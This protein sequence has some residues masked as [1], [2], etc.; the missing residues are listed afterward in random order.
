[1]EVWRRVTRGAILEAFT[2]L[3]LQYEAWHTI[4]HQRVLVGRI[5][6]AKQDA[7]LIRLKKVWMQLLR[8]SKSSAFE[9]FF[10]NWSRSQQVEAERLVVLAKQ[11]AGEA[12]LRKTWSKW[13]HRHLREVCDSLLQNFAEAKVLALEHEIEQ[14]R[15]I[16]A[17]AK[18]GA[19]AKLKLIWIHKLKG[20]EGVALEAL[21]ENYGRWLAWREEWSNLGSPRAHRDS[22]SIQIPGS[23][24]LHLALDND[25]AEATIL[26]LIESNPVAAK[27]TDDKGRL[28]VH[29]A[30]SRIA[31][32]AS[33]DRLL[34]AY[35]CATVIPDNKGDLPI[36]IAARHGATVAA[37]KLL[38]GNI[39][40]AMIVNHVGDTA[41][42]TAT[43]HSRRDAQMVSLLIEACPE[44]AACTNQE[45]RTALHVAVSHG[46][47]LGLGAKVRH[48]KRGEGLVK[49]VMSDGRLRV[50]FVGGDMHRYGPRSWPKLQVIQPAAGAG[51]DQ[52]AHEKVVALLLE[53]NKS[54]TTVA[55]HRRDLPIH[56]AAT[57][58]AP[59]C[60]V[61]MLLQAS[62][63]LKAAQ[64][65]G[66]E[67]DSEARVPW[68][69]LKKF[70]SVTQDSD[71]LTPL[72][73]AVAQNRRD[74]A[75]VLT[76]LLDA[77]KEGAVMTDTMGR[78]P[79]HH[80]MRAMLEPEVVRHLAAAFPSAV[81]Q[82]DK[83]GLT[84]VE[85]MR[86]DRSG[87]TDSSSLKE[88]KMTEAE[89]LMTCGLSGE[90]LCTSL[91]AKELDVARKCIENE[92]LNLQ[93]CHPA[94]FVNA[95][96]AMPLHMALMHQSPEDIIFVLLKAHPE[97][98]ARR[99]ALS[100]FSRLI[101]T[102][103]GV[104]ALTADAL[105]HGVYALQI[106]A[107]SQASEAVKRQVFLAF[108]GAIANAS[109]F[110]AIRGNWGDE[111]VAALLSADPDAIQSPDV[112]G[113]M[114]VH[115]A[116]ELDRPDATVKR[117]LECH[118][119]AAQTRDASGNLPLDVV[120]DS[121]GFAGSEALMSC[122]PRLVAK[123]FDRE[124]LLL[125][126]AR[127][128]QVQDVYLE[129]A[130]ALV[131]E[132]GAT[133]I[134]R[135]PLAPDIQARSMGTASINPR[136]KEYFKTLGTILGRYLLHTTI[137]LH[138]SRTCVVHY[139]EDQKGGGGKNQAG[140][141]L[142]L[143]KDRFQFETEITA[144]WVD[145]VPISASA[146]INV[147]R[148]HTPRG[149]DIRDP[150][151]KQQEAEETEDAD[152]PYILVMD[153]GERSLHDA[154][155]KERIAGVSQAKVVEI[156]RSVTDCVSA[157]HGRGVCHGDIKQRN[158][159]RQTVSRRWILCDMDAA[160]KVGHRIGLKSS[161]A[162]A[163]PELAHCT[164]TAPATTEGEAGKQLEAASS[165]DIW[166][167]GV[168]LFELC[169][170]RTL[171]SQDI[172]NDELVEDGDPN[173]ICLWHTISDGD[174]NRLFA[175]SHET[176]KEEA[177]WNAKQLIRWMLKGD[178]EE[179]PTIGQ[180]RAHPFFTPS[181]PRGR[182]LSEKYHV[183]ISHAQ[184]EASGTVGTLFHMFKSLGL[185]AWVDMHQANLT[186]E[187]MM[188][189]VRASDA[190]L[191]ILT[192][193]VL[194]RWFCQEA[195]FRP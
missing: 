70:S 95:E 28:P 193:T 181:N 18:D 8:G 59:A 36:H 5:A 13:L 177:A 23:L 155:A 190:F 167:L 88:M 107:Q 99:I 123:G 106:A 29:I 101:S 120:A 60:I 54:A 110:D 170:G 87:S 85:L 37:A 62:E 180:V 111:A 189:G 92:T 129:A 124:F 175:A 185:S 147:L 115:L 19:L 91:A 187:G 127:E 41:L 49:E 84:P 103:E 65:G 195:S 32:A 2:T 27:T 31:S 16:A 109:V 138:R 160:A 134:D 22:S 116:M 47:P 132:A 179:R 143:M 15:M 168:V 139:A 7:G 183:F 174:L 141:A 117:L 17:S 35:P 176:R 58:S 53:A 61:K 178:P 119:V 125:H 191:L 14:S 38:E 46:A 67:A 122:Y 151:G 64:E 30:A 42:H 12:R 169:A 51:L 6:T 145:G 166:S 55:D 158:I 192:K 173:R 20:A 90:A 171:F 69:Q 163:P 161:A 133:G 45:G 33:V 43:R 135:S 162:Y 75:G 10:Q 126:M 112:D 66:V 137:P 93:A 118:P 130:K 25:A 113:R 114:A 131:E 165:F 121:G 156:M 4:E 164:F 11:Q 39:E 52:A 79:L 152:F 98:T 105:E 82:R 40:T 184:A 148:W 128:M 96:G 77:D 81:E 83:H 140:C 86:R 149:V 154:C 48:A 182:V 56:I 76:A 57:H 108:P 153:R 102:G 26:K 150:R 146:V 194:T 63:E 89:Y 3:R 97:A 72:H 157:L 188:D 186:Y 104:Y 50:V 73:I 80:A 1:V 68:Y 74:S 9:S 94:E 136:V 172:A 100:A 24:A 159:L 71:G 34:S 144:R 21:R 44:A 142:K 78:L